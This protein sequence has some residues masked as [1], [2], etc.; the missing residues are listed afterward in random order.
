MS[1]HRKDKNIDELKKYFNTVI[2][3]VSSVFTDV[4]SEM[5]GLEWG[6]LY[7]AYHKKSL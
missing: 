6:Q 3:W 1:K 7:E 4:E 5:R 2:G